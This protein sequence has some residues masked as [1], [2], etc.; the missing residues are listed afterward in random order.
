MLDDL[1][2]AIEKLDIPADGAALV[3][4]LALRDQLDARIAEAVGVFDAH[5]LWDIDAA[6]S[7]TAWLKASASMTSR[8][9]GR[10]SSLARRLRQLPVCAAAFADGSLSG[11]QVEAILALV[12][13]STVAA[14]AESEAEL[15]PYLVPLSLSGCAR[16]M[17]AW[18]AQAQPDPV[19]PGEPERGLHLSQTLDDRYVLDASLDAEGGAVVA[20]ALRLATTDDT[21]GVRSPATRRADALVDLCRFSLDHHHARPGGRHRPHLNVV[22]DLDALQAGRGG[23]VIDGPRLDGPEVARLLC[24]GALHRVLMSGRSAVLDYG[25][26]PGAPR[27][28]RSRRRCGV[29]WSSVTSTVAFRA[30][31]VL[32]SGARGTT[33]SGSPTTGPPSS[34]ISSWSAPGTTTGCI[35]PVGRPSSCPTPPSRS[36]TP[37]ESSAARHHH[38][39]SRGGERVGEGPG[40]E[41]GP[42]SML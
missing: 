17:A 37:T 40:A 21:E 11:G 29:R 42:R 34:G 8:S 1:A 16:A 9:A 10:L 32:R 35:N 25:T 19:D 7:M 36:P 22:I 5:G 2:T 4:A 31:T 26:R 30:V 39:P 23:R 27:P 6:T 38:G 15:V 14:F 41:G 18:K 13:D 24:D 3:R 20:T 28:G 12:D 33:S